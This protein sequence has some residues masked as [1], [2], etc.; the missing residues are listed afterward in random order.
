MVLATEQHASRRL[1]QEARAL[2]AERLNHEDRKPRDVRAASAYLR[3]LY[4][5]SPLLSAEE[6]K[7]LFLRLAELRSHEAELS[8][9]S[10][11]LHCEESTREL[12]VVRDEILE[13][14]N[15][16]V[17]SNLRL[18]VSIAKKFRDPRD[19]EFHELISE[20]NSVLLRAVD[21]FDISYGYRFST[22]AT[23]AV[24]RSFMNLCNVNHRQKQRFVSGRTERFD[25]VEGE[26]GVV[27]LDIESSHAREI[28][29][30]LDQLDDRERT[31]V[32]ERFGLTT[33]RKGKTYREIGEDFNLS[34]ERIRQIVVAALKKMKEELSKRN[35]VIDLDELR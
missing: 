27:D 1:G 30:L 13:L 28:G 17:E 34:K 5:V 32:E 25:E 15:H 2:L 16:I 33:R 6:E 12:K 10:L 19:L 11:D 7:C 9:L 14:R 31:V 24:R 23:T 4:R 18:V 22:Y 29:D 20:G 35:V 8:T 3:D 21:L 26:Y